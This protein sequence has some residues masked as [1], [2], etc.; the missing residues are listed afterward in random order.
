MNLN[1]FVELSGNELLN[2]DGG[3]WLGNALIFAGGVVCCFATG[4]VGFGVGIASAVIG[5][6]DS[7][8]W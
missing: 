5:F 1:N 3:G 2:V 4:P 6:S 7:Q 8:G